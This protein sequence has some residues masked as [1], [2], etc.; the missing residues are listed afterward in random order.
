MKVFHEGCKEFSF[1]TLMISCFNFVS[2][3]HTLVPSTSLVEFT[4]TR[5]RDT[6]VMSKVEYRLP[7]NVE[8]T[9]ELSCR[10]WMVESYTRRIR[11]YMHPLIEPMLW[12]AF[13][14]KF[15]TNWSCLDMIA[16]C[17][18]CLD[19]WPRHNCKNQS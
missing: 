11:V 5:W 13:H 8:S 7:F 17:F 19:I 10:N 16:N 3:T 9:S 6:S 18:F 2:Y 15:Q 12:A 14:Q 4:S 1:A